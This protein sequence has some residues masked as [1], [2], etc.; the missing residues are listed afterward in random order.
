MFSG[1]K[2]RMHWEQMSQMKVLQMRVS[3]KNCLYY[4][5]RG[6][7]SFSPPTQVMSDLSKFK[8]F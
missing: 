5:M 3:T 8:D 6:E 4:V 7:W 1:G 2:E